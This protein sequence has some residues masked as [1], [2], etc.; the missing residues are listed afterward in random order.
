M[1]LLF[2][3]PFFYS[4]VLVLSFFQ[5]PGHIVYYRLY[6]ELI[7]L[8]F[9]E[10]YPF[11]VKPLPYPA[12]SLSPWINARTLKIH[13]DG[14]YAAYVRKLNDIL[15]NYPQYQNLPLEALILKQ[16]F[17]P[18]NIRNDIRKNA[19]GAFNHQLYFS[20]M[21]HPSKGRISNSFEKI[22]ADNFGSVQNLLKDLKA[23]AMS[24]FGSG[25]AYLVSD[26]SG[27]MHILVL[28]N[29]ETPIEQRL[30]PL[31]PI[32]VWEHAYYLQFQYHREQYINNFCH[33]I[34]WKEVERNYYN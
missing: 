27:K 21:I 22:I 28:K 34:N 16:A 33:V 2:V 20:S 18:E 13:H 25:Y 7:S 32:D 15:K 8:N 31:L 24:V 23:A 29:Q 14:H 30:N 1:D 12:S 26:M 19:G 4:N 17:L 9:P 5:P 10:H 6:K 3:S 11:N